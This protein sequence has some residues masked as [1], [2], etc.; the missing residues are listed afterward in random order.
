MLLVSSNEEWIPIPWGTKDSLLTTCGKKHGPTSSEIL[1]CKTN[2]L[3]RQHPSGPFY[4]TSV[5]LPCSNFIAL[6]NAWEKQ[7]TE[8]GFLWFTAPEPLPHTFRALFLWTLKAEHHAGI[9]WWIKAASGL[10]PFSILF[11][12]RTPLVGLSHPYSGSVFVLWLILLGNTF[13]DVPGIM[14]C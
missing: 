13:T 11:L 14:L 9:L 1:T 4:F 3:G 12:S 8:K 10:S 7:L 6:P 5:R 2:P